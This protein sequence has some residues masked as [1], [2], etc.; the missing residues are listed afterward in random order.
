MVQCPICGKNVALELINSHL[1]ECENDKEVIE[2]E[3]EPPKKKVKTALELAQSKSIGDILGKKSKTPEKR[4]IRKE[5]KEDIKPSYISKTTAAE[6]SQLEEIKQL[7]LDLHKPLA[8]KLRPKNLQEYIGQ[9][10]LL[11]NE[12]ILKNLI[13]SNQLPSMILWGPPGVG[14]TTLAR[15]ITKFHKANKFIELNATNSGTAQIKTI[16]ENSI[17]DFKLLNKK[18]ILFIDEIHRFNKNQQD[19]FLPFI[20][21]G[22]IKIIG[23]TTE[24]P[25]FQLNNALLSRCKVFKLEK[26]EPIEITKV[27]NKGLLYLN[28]V[29]KLILNESLINLDKTTIDHISLISNGDSRIALNILE[30]VNSYFKDFK[31]KILITDIKPILNKIPTLYDKGG[32]FHYDSISALHKSIRGSNINASL[33]YLSIMLK[34]GEDPLYIARRLIRI[35]SEDIGVVDESC[36]P[37]AI[38]TY[39]A[40]QFVG[41]PEADLSLAQCVVKLANA[42]KSVKIY[43]AWKKIKEV[44]NDENYSIDIPYQLRNA[45]TQLMKEIGYSKGYKYNPDFKDGKVNQKY[46][47]DSKLEDIDFFGESKDLG[48]I[49]DYD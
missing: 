22:T 48:D 35:A 14:K 39:Q 32:D 2:I 21:S 3:D 28:K 15:I 11:G 26:L 4:E 29:R 10:H 25:S 18:T 8:E 45:P 33:F 27:L 23:A 12:G 6:Q 19:L 17:K 49:I 44:I 36:L 46:F 7:K 34:N 1:D 31:G 47:F 43:R 9:E 5:I 37:F 16:F 40:I 41:L 24:N 13:V 30:L 20:E 38:S 42:K